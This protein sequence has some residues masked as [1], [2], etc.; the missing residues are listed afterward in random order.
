MFAQFL[1]LLSLVPMGLLTVVLRIWGVRDDVHRTHSPVRGKLLRAPGESIRKR[2]DDLFN[3]IMLLSLFCGVAPAFLLAWLLGTKNATVPSPVVWAP[4]LILAIGVYAWVL[5]CLIG[6][7]QQRRRYRLGLSGELAVGQE[8]NRLVAD[9]CQVFH[10]FPLAANWNIDHIVVSPNGVFAIETKT[11]SKG[12]ASAT[13]KAHEVIYDGQV[14]QFPNHYD[15]K[16]VAQAQRQAKSLSLMLSTAL[17]EPVVVT[18][19]LVLPGWFVQR[20]TSRGVVVLNHHPRELRAA[21]LD[22]RQPDLGPEL[23]ARIT[24]EI[25]AKCRDVEF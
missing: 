6:L 14:L 21:I 17:D 16:M 15:K 2:V 24:A 18:P 3:Q 22:A 1:V 4:L 25:D 8:L 23:V 20:K 12:K 9:G 10:D 5:T 11:R 19:I 7:L 13:Q